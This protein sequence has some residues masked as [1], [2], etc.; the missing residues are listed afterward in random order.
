MLDINSNY[1]GIYYICLQAYKLESQALANCKHFTTQ[2]VF[3]RASVLEISASFF[4]SD[5]SIEVYDWMED[6]GESRDRC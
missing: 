6:V 1:R 2:N 5:L 4:P 3:R